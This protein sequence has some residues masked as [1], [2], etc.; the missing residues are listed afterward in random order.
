MERN[1]VWSSAIG[2]TD[3]TVTVVVEMVP[4]AGSFLIWQLLS[5]SLGPKP[6]EGKLTFG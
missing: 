2:L 4:L 1:E 5:F 3:S 6:W